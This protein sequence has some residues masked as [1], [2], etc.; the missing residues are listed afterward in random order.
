M[1]TRRTFLKETAVAC[2]I[3]ASAPLFWR[4][5]AGAAEA[6]RDATILVV[7]ELTGGNDGLNTVVPHGDDVYVKSRPTLAIKPDKTLKLDDRVGLNDALKPL[8]AFWE[9]GDLAVVQQVGYPEPNRS[10]FESMA[11]WQGGAPGQSLPTG[12]LGRAADVRPELKARH[13]GP[14]G[15]PLGVRGLHVVPQSIADPADFHLAPGAMLDAS[16]IA[17]GGPAL[18]AVRARFRGAREL[19]TKLDGLPPAEATA[20]EDDLP[21]QGRMDTIRRMILADASTRVYYTSLEGFDTHSAQQYS[22]RRLLE[23]LGKGIAALLDG[24][25][26]HRLDER[27]AVLAFSEFG[28]RLKENGNAGTDHGAPGPVML[29]GPGVK[30]GLQGPHPDL[31]RLD[32]TGDSLFAV[33]FRDVYA[34]VLRDWLDVDPRAVL[35]ERPSAPSL[36]G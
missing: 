2:S 1:H 19:L 26:E 23:S 21:F 24:L 20:E 5:A 11:I 32:E 7:V 31:T 3:G 28:R 22:H 36:F 12:W 8:H 4:R 29:V 34:G 15:A 14:P 30:G 13:V 6:R 17:E 35:G 25:K 16:S 33:D 10:H 9:R 18:D 27:V